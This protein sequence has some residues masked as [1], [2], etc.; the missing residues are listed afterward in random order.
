MDFSSLVLAPAMS[1]FGKPVSI[2]PIASRPLGPSYGARGVWTVSAVSI[3]TEDGGTLSNRSLKFG[4]RL[5]EFPAPPKQGDW[6]STLVHHL[7]LGYWEGDI[8][9]NA[10]IDFMVDDV[11]PD[12]QGGVTLTLKRRV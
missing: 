7:P 9:P 1:V 4:I 5:G 3:I 2:L 8:D 10:N 6:V 11:Q 12:G